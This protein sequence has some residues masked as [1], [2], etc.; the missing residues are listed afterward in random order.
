[1]KKT[2]PLS[3][4]QY[5]VYVE[6]VQHL[7]E[8]YYNL[9]FLYVLDGSMDEAKLKAAIEQ[10]VAAHPTLFTRIAL[11]AQGEPVQTIDDSETF[12]LEV[13]HITDIEAEKKGLVAPFDI[14][15]DRL[16]RIR[17]MKDS[18]HFYLFIDTHH[19]ISDGASLK[20]LLSDIDAAYGGQSLEP[21]TV[22]LADVACEEVEK[23]QTAAFE[24]AKQWYAQ[25]FDCSD[26]FTQLIPD[27]EEPSAEIGVVTRKLGASVATVE[28]FRE[29]YGIF[30]NTL[31]S[32]VYG[33]LLAK[34]NNEKEALF[35]TAY[36]GRQDKRLART[37][38][39]FVKTLPVWM[40]FT[41]DTTTLDFLKAGQ[42]Q[43]SGCREHDTYTFTD[44][45]TDLNLQM[46]R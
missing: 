6:C 33:F 7:G 24:E 34:Y 28:A 10:A 17:L 43:I 26:T 40:K 2:A 1:M 18:Q 45:M 39:M 29:Q 37:V 14:Y 30:K 23:R 15:N 46:W 20:V 8:I 9:P 3:K 25:T 13:E 12:T 16:F 4:T 27:L 22:T 19:T 42:E 35:C 32:A 41:D 38:G 44:V 36:K 5:G 21:E 11:N 31:F